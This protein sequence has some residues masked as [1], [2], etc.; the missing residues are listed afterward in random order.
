[1]GISPPGGGEAYVFKEL[2]CCVRQIHARDEMEENSI[3]LDEQRLIKTIGLD[4][5]YRVLIGF[6]RFAY[7]GQK[8][9]LFLLPIL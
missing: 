9:I 8:D 1:M 7:K 5:K 6:F 2:A 3:Q 4:R